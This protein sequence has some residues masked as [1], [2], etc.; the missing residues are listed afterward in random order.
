MWLGGALGS[1]ALLA[2]CTGTAVDKPTSHGTTTVT[3]PAETAEDVDT[4]VV[5]VDTASDSETGEP[6]DSADTSRPDDTS[7]PDGCLSGTA[8]VDQ[9]AV[10]TADGVAGTNDGVS[11]QLVLGHSASSVGAWILGRTASTPSGRPTAGAVVQYPNLSAPD[12]WLGLDPSE[13]E[14]EVLAAGD[15][16]DSPGDDLIIGIEHPG[17]VGARVVVQ[18][19]GWES[20]SALEAPIRLE[21]FANGATP[22]PFPGDTDGDGQTDLHIGWADHFDRW[23]GPLGTGDFTAGDGDQRL[24]GDTRQWGS[25]GDV[26]GDGYADAV[27]ATYDGVVVMLGGPTGLTGS[28]AE[29]DHAYPGPYDSGADLGGIAMGDAPDGTTHVAI[30][31]NAPSEDDAVAVVFAGISGDF[32]EVS[33]GETGRVALDWADLDGLPGDELVLGRVPSSTSEGGLW[34]FS[35]LD[36]EPMRVFAEPGGMLL[37]ALFAPVPSA[38]GTGDDLIVLDPWGTAE[39]QARLYRLEL[40]TD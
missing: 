13:G 14:L 21:S 27:V 26:D 4:D 28:P 3:A 34:I 8:T 15:V 35:A 20:G 19:A 36:A 5:P 7:T 40:C 33:I 23:S 22:V 37:G 10:L 12:A 30:T 25:S 38:D 2:G 17:L 32:A 18:P 11:G 1:N 29:P 16:D 6:V 31:W 39:R 24:V 9:L